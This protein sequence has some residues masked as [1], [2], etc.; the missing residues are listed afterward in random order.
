MTPDDRWAATDALAHLRSCADVWG[1]CISTILAEDHPT[2]RAINPHTA[3]QGTSYHRQAF[4][5]SFNAYRRQRREL[6]RQ[7]GGLTPEEWLRTATVVGAGA[8]LE[9]SVH[10]YA[11]W[12]ARH[13]RTHINQF[14]RVVQAVRA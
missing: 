14:A 7:L 6:L 4:R 5:P 12:L 9:R 10:Y 13:E 8:P 11:A 1:G 2:I 3:I